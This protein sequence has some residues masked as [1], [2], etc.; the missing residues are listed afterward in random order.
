MTEKETIWCVCRYTPVELFTGGFGCECLRLDP[1]RTSF[2]CADSC[3]HPN[4]CG[5][6][7]GV[8]EEVTEQNIRYLILTDCC[9]VM[10]RVCDVLQQEAQIEFIHLLPLP[11]RNGERERRLFAGALNELIREWG[12]C[13]GLAFDSAGFLKSWVE[14][15]RAGK[16]EL[17]KLRSGPHLTLRGAHAGAHLT[18]L[19]KERISLPLDDQSCTGTRII[20]VPEEWEAI[21]ESGE[22]FDEDEL[23]L[24]VSSQRRRLD[25]LRHHCDQRNAPV[26]RHQIFGLLIPAPCEEAF[27]Y[28]LLDRGS[29]GRRRTKALAFCLFG[30]IF[31]PGG[32]HR[33]QHGVF[34][35]TFWRGRLAFF[36][37][38]APDRKCYAL[39]NSLRNILQGVFIF[40]VLCRG[41]KVPLGPLPAFIQDLFSPG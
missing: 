31:G 6:G 23:L 9:D 25:E 20:K 27:L 36:D 15:Y 17:E 11:H 13:C 10:R 8:I 30:H 3:A 12:L 22:D 14:S 35:K 18:G 21:A 1:S 7:K 33:A 16:A 4:L 24:P 37:L 40:P 41:T 34:R 28:Q 38:R 26:R 32:F 39:H 5:F 2:D 29:T 19:V